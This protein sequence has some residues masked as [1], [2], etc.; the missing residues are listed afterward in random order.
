MFK[1]FNKSIPLL[2]IL[3]LA[4]I[5]VIGYSIEESGSPVRVLFKT[6]GGNVIFSHKAHLSEYEIGCKDCHHEIDSGKPVSKYDCRECH[7]AGTD[8]DSICDDRPIHK[9]CIGANCIDCHKEMG[10]DESDCGLCHK[11]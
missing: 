4:V 8:Y 10:M 11:Q 9:Q 6:K 5:G 7:R 3:I 1:K 2:I